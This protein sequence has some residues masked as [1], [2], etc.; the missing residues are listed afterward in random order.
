M[1]LS[2]MNGLP[3]KFVLCRI[4]GYCIHLE[5]TKCFE[6]D[7]V[8]D[9]KVR[10]SNAISSNN[11][12]CNVTQRQHVFKKILQVNRLLTYHCQMFLFIKHNRFF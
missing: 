7:I 4:D 12:T 10:G 5:N 2:L 11:L 8:H 3:F 1:N 6:K 9:F